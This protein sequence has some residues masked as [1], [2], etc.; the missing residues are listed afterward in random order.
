MVVVQVPREE[1]LVV[2]QGDRR[3]LEI[4]RMKKG[5]S[6]NVAQEKGDLLGLRLTG[7]G[8]VCDLMQG[9]TDLASFLPFPPQLC[10]CRRL[11]ELRRTPRT[12]HPDKK[13]NSN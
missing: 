5:R 12:L 1:P 10:S 8:G 6:E 4:W 11:P 2:T 13:G 7:M 9:E 3:A